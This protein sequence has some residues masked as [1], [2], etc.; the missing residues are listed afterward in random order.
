VLVGGGVRGEARTD[1]GLVFILERG[2]SREKEEK[3][4]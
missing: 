1:A 2:E 3:F 4:Y